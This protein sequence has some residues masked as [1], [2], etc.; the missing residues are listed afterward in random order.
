MKLRNTLKYAF[1]ASLLS[2]NINAKEVE[3][4]LTPG[5]ANDVWYSLTNGVVKSESKDNWDI[6]FQIGQ[7]GGIQINEQK[8]LQLWV[9]PNSTEDTWSAAIDT[10]GMADS[11]ELLHNSLDTWDIGAFNC[12]K[13]GF[14]ND[15]DFGWGA[16]NM[17]THAI[18]GNKVFIIKTPAKAYKKVFIESLLS[19][20]YTFK[21]ADFDGANEK[22]YE[23][24]KADY[25]TK[26]YIYFSLDE[27]KVV[28]R[29]PESKSW[30]LVIGK[31]VDLM[32]VS[33]GDT[34]PYPVTG[35]RS[36]KAGRVAEIYADNAYLVVA[37]EINAENYK[38]SIT[39]IGSDWKKYGS[40]YTVDNQR[41]Y[42]FT[43]DSTKT[44]GNVIH[45]IIFKT[46]DG[47]STGKFTFDLD[48]ATSIVNETAIN[49]SVKVYPSEIE[50][51]GV[52]SISSSAKFVNSIAEI[53]NLNGDVVLTKSLN[54]NDTA[55]QINNMAAGAY[56][57]IIKQD[58][59]VISKNRIIVK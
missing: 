1:I 43:Y 22:A 45:K 20:T 49:N 9:V 8:E 7:K 34:V 15:G 30:D 33:A 2:T 14:A 42:F 24:K 11:W 6:A 46:F 35:I 47:T 51:N 39:A 16:Y 10:V 56:F 32:E 50:K 59:K 52:L 4:D 5:Y 37:P 41:A 3:I 12:G 36:N 26:N 58:N 13:D 54:S 23:V 40:I 48:P 29:E 44:D 38:T 17:A 21:I 31:Y 27:A 53:C 55:I 57:L 28:D 25:I 18:N 19:G